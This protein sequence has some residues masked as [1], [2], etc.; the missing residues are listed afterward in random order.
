MLVKKAKPTE[1]A[2]ELLDRSTCQVQVAAVLADKHGTFSWGTNHQG[3]DGYGMHAE[4]FCWLRSNRKRL[5]EAT[6]YVAARRKK[7]GSVVLAKP[8]LQCQQIIRKIG[9]VIYRDKD[10]KWK[11]LW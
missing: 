8:C 2:V 3:F 10:G 5:S 6:M 7:S 11:K 4:H 9:T 1:L